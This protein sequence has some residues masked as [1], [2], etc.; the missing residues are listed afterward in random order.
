[1]IQRKPSIPLYAIVQMCSKVQH[2]ERFLRF[3]FH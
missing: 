1:M 2:L 3:F